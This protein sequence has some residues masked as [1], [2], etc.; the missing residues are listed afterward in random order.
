MAPLINVDDLHIEFSGRRR[1]F[2]NPPPIKA[3][4]G[5]SIAI[6]R[7]TTY[8]LVGE[9]G[10]GKSTLARAILQLVEPTSGAIRLDGFPIDMRTPSERSAFRRRV[11]AVLQDPYASLNRSHS[12]SVIVGDAISLYSEVSKGEERDALVVELLN[13]VGLNSTFLER[14]PYEMSGGQ[15]QRVSIARSLAIQPDLIV[16]DEVTSAL[17]VSVQ[18]QVLNLLSDIQEETGLALLLIAHNLEVVEHMSDQ[19]GVMYLGYLVE[20]GPARAVY[21]APAH[22][23]TEMLIA[24]SP[25]ANPVLQRERR[26]V[27]RS[28]PR[29]AEPPSPADLPPGCPFA[30]R[31]PL[32]LEICR[33]EMPDPTPAGHGGLVSCHLHTH[34]PELA[35]ET[36][37]DL[38]SAVRTGV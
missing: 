14:R 38:L 10:S 7:G 11:Q 17:D 2:R 8:G 29:D 21:Q 18:S 19:V 13:Q 22:P 4:N 34:G 20:S 35:G 15:C 30:N 32:A 24:S 12:V 16:A 23:Y 1:L 27:R 33:L 25:V 5:A 28:F 31:C 37:I 3:V 26:A 9:S 36:V 6:P